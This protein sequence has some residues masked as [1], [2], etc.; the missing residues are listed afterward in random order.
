MIGAIR[1]A[2]KRA[3]LAINPE[4]PADAA[5]PFLDRIDLLLVM[6]VNP[7]WG[8]QPFM[9]EVLPK[10]AALRRE[11][12]ARGL[13]LPIGVDGGVN[14]ETIGP[15]HARG[16]RRAGHGQGAV[17]HQRRPAAD[18]RRAAR[19]GT[20]LGC[21]DADRRLSRIGHHVRHPF[22]SR[23]LTRAASPPIAALLVIAV[24]LAACGDSVQL[25]FVP[26]TDPT[27]QPRELTVI[28]VQQ[29]SSEPI[30]GAT[31]TVGDVTA[32]TGADGTALVTAPRGAEVAATADGYDPASGTVPDEGDLTLTLRS[33]V[34]SGTIS[35]QA[36]DPV[37]GARVFVDGQT[38]WVRSDERGAYALPGV[39]EQGTLI[40]K[41]A[42]YRLAEVPLDGSATADVALQ[43]FE[44]RA[45]YAPGAVF[46]GAGR[47]DDLLRLIDR[48]EANA[49]VI[50][51]K[52]TG[53]YLYY[54]TNLP[55]A[56]RSGADR[57]PIFELEQLLPRLEERG[58]YTIARMVVM[59]DNT[60]GASRPELAVRNSATGGPWHDFGGGIWL[61]PFNPGVAEYI[62]A[63]A[64]DLADKG[65]D[66]V[67]LGL[68]PLLQRR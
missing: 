26:T 20:G 17:C 9:V 54:E 59:K 4:T 31:L 21:L 7:G 1:A 39:P 2:G 8:G 52:E 63:I 47:L 3:G 11:A 55:E 25:P 49:M 6:T 13:D 41:L 43:P 40:V 33:N 34:V 29:G 61:D 35:D 60:V 30:A 68:R 45:L 62:A 14:L 27:A 15:A 36:G 42:G 16:R 12:E 19:R 28:A 67:Q 53:G 44:A 23:S 18:S 24:L 32:V 57:R 65:F 48:T 37:A 58:I 66:E 10:L 5:H 50:D 64:G 46:E 38:T 22:R 51:V 56:E